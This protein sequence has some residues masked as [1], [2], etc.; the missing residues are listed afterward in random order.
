MDDL[1]PILTAV[2]VFGLE[3]NPKDVGVL[4]TGCD[5]TFADYHNYYDINRTVSETCY[6]NYLKYSKLLFGAAAIATPWEAWESID[7]C[8]E[9]FVVGHNH[10][11]GRRK[12]KF[13]NSPHS[14]PPA[15]LWMVLPWS[16]FTVNVKIKPLNLYIPCTM[17]LFRVDLCTMSTCAYV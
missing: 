11:F 9:R 15:A 6:M 12:L 1:F 14:L 4:F 17:H 5:A 16:S 3:L 7:R 10:A 2:D 8:V 13:T